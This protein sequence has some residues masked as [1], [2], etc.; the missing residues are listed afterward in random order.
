MRVWQCC[1]AIEDVE[2]GLD[3]VVTR[4]NSGVLKKMKPEAT[5]KEDWIV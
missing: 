4:V 5:R 2:D 1:L 3:E